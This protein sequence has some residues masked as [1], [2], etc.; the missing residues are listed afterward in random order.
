MPKNA[1][2]R[3]RMHGSDLT[4]LQRVAK[5]KGLAASEYAR[6]LLA[7]EVRRDQSAQRVRNALRTARPGRLDD[8]AAM[9]LA[10]E[11]RHRTRS[12]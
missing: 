10:D 2:F 9:A 11:A 6:R 3:L 4:A 8:S 1:V 7:L 5:E 12:R